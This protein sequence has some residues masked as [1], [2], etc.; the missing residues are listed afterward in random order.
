M[1]RG[2]Q[3]H[4][5]GKRIYCRRHIRG[6]LEPCL[7]LLL[8]LGDSYGY[9]LTTALVPFGLGNVDPSLVYRAL[10]DLERAGLVESEWQPAT[11][12]GPARRVYRITAAGD[13]HLAGW[14]GDLR[15]T[16]DVLHYFLE[17]YDQ[18]I[19]TDAEECV[20]VPLEKPAVNCRPKRT[21]ESEAT[22]STNA[23]RGG[24]LN[25]KI[26]VSSDGYDLDAPVSSV[27]GRCGAYI[28]VE[29]ENME[30]QALDNP[31]ASVPS[32]AGVRA[33][34]F[35]VEH[36]A[37]VVLTGNVGPNAFEVFR[38]AG[39]DVLL[40]HEGTVREAIEAYKLGQL[41]K[42]MGPNVPPH[43]GQ[44]VSGTEEGMEPAVEE[45]GRFPAGISREREIA[46]L[47]RVV[48]DLRQQLA[49]IVTRIKQLE[50]EE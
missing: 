11:T 6:F 12:L 8:H 34:Q 38:S 4:G 3:R 45:A 30:Y 37:K 36:G 46:E 50:E 39:V 40:A 16:D 43:A 42:A 33:A 13:R 28:F 7:L 48:A 47:R 27:F 23:E 5:R 10:R 22:K 2:G 21:K 32:G 25:M 26:V 18:H 49:E 15:D 24:N 44:G 41:E 9:D 20:A 31:M 1:G 19:H 17:V 29:T 14:V 35:V